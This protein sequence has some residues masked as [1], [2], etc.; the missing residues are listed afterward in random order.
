MKRAVRFGIA[1]VSGSF[2]FNGDSALIRLLFIIILVCALTSSQATAQNK[3]SQTLLGLSEDERNET[4]THLLRDN[5]V[6]CDR[7]TRTLFNGAT[8]KLSPDIRHRSRRVGR[9]RSSDIRR[10]SGRVGRGGSPDIR[11]PSSSAPSRWPVVRG[12]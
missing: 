3:V 6:K 11:R 8:S 4:F 9:G 5:N 2:G 12:A 10:R 1:T 7:V